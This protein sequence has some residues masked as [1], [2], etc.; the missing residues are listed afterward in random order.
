MTDN[1]SAPAPAA[2]GAAPQTET[3]NSPDMKLE[4]DSAASEG[5]TESKSNP[6]PK[7][8][9]PKG[10]EAKADAAADK[11]G[12]EKV[13]EDQYEIK[14]DGKLETLSRAEMIKFAQM[15]KAG[16]KRMQEAVEYQKLT[17]AQV[18]NLFKALKED[19]ESVLSDP[20]IGH[21]PVELAKK[22][23]A[24]KMEQDA[25]SPEQKKLEEALSK[26]AAAEHKLAQIEK[27]KEAER[28]QQEEA[29]KAQEVEADFNTFQSQKDEAIKQYKLP[30]SPQVEARM[31]TIMEVAREN[32]LPVTMSDVAKIVRDELKVDLQSQ[33]TSL[34]DE[35]FE[36][37]IGDV[38][39]TRVKNLT[40]KKAKSAPKVEVADVSKAPKKEEAKPK[41]DINDLLK[42]EHLRGK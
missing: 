34:S 27:Q 2:A 23:L 7:G 35:E 3:V 28:L 14:I 15:G 40:L 4:T 6:T 32:D 42:P 12:A 39:L 8:D 17:K 37:F 13:S 18:E 38:G 33:L 25:K 26:A 9:A 30:N 36:D 1:Q 41:F 21:D 29:K 19:P 31:I 5:N 22:I 20:E 11:V 24:K 10:Q 16:Q